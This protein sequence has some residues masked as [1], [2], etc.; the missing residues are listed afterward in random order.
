MITNALAI[1]GASWIISLGWRY[2]SNGKNENNSKV[3]ETCSKIFEKRLIP[4]TDKYIYYIIYPSSN[5]GIIKIGKT[6]NYEKRYQQYR[7]HTDVFEMHLYE[8]SDET[9]AEN[10]IKKLLISYKRPNSPNLEEKYI[11]SEKQIRVFFDDVTK[12][13]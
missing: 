4:K 7:T 5:S 1:I 13:I 10:N 9:I 3:M 12:T 11:C 8:V 6:S 2:F